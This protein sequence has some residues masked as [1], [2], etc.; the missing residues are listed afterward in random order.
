[1]TVSLPLALL[2]AFTR[3]LTARLGETF[4]LARKK[5]VF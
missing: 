3:R 4:R 2:V 1:V 5:R